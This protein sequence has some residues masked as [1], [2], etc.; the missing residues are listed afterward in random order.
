M[1]LRRISTILLAAFALAAY[2]QS[3]T[4]AQTGGSRSVT[5]GDV[6]IQI[7]E[8]GGNTEVRLTVKKEDLEDLLEALSRME[9]AQPATLAAPASGMMQ[10]MGLKK[11]LKRLEKD[12]KN[13]INKLAPMKNYCVE[14]RTAPD[15]NSANVRETWH[16]RLGQEEVKARY[17]VIYGA[18]RET[19][20]FVCARSG[21]CSSHPNQCQ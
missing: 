11:R 13:G 17:R 9:E 21:A 2:A 7:S 5:E 8:R 1:T 19:Q 3:T 18:D 16:S 12:V 4:T 6:S 10:P 15:A 20:R 14:W